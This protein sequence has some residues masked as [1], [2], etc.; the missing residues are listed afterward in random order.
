MNEVVMNSGG[1]YGADT[2]WDYYARNAG[3]KQINHYRDQEN[4]TLSSSLNKRGIKA[5]VLSKE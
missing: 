1:A 2:A 5:T 3:V 4:Q